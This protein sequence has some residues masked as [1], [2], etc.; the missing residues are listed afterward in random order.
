[1][2]FL[3][4]SSPALAQ[5][6]SGTWSGDIND[7]D[8]SPYSSLTLKLRQQGQQI[9]GTY[10][11]IT[12]NGG[13]IDCPD[14]ETENLHGTVTA[15]SAVVN[16][17]S[18]FGGKNGKSELRFNG[19]KL[20]WT[21]LQEPKRGQYYAPEKYILARLVPDNPQTTTSKSFSTDKFTITISNS[22]GD[23]L[24]PCEN[25]LYFGIRESDASSLS[26]FG[27]TL[28][29]S[30]THKVNGATFSNGNIVYQVLFDTPQLRVTQGD[31]VLVDQAGRW[32]N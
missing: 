25:M 11:Y 3:F 14:D 32:G 9:S 4:L 26:L 30:Q 2:S 18:S 16:F 13:R 21:L 12:Q 5:N 19:D 24:T 22:C 8:G 10:C 6:Y 31:K 20:L 27:K 1:M 15:Q 7:D 17:D 29:D 23:F 28:T